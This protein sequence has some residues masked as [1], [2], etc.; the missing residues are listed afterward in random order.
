MDSE[1]TKLF[2]GLITALGTIAVAFLNF[3]QT[4]KIKAELLEKFETAL[5][6]SQK[7]STT[8]L[9]R[10]IHGLR[11]NYAD[12]VE[13]VKHDE[14]SKIVYA[15]GK[16]PGLVC[17]EQGEFRYTGIGK[18]PMFKFLDRWCT[19]AIMA[20][21][22]AISLGSYAAIACSRNPKVIAFGF[23]SLAV[24]SFIFA[25]QLRQIRYD[26]MVSNLIHPGH[27]AIIGD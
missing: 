18:N 24:S 3:G 10:L 16:S 9:F 12:I 7:H 11:M 27:P 21:F 6:K 2:F 1:I 20:F 13:L 5:E 15:L 22:G 17:Y 26:R 19:R 14:C 23:V 8:E 4:R 25:T